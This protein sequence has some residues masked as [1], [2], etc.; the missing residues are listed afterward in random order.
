MIFIN[1][2]GETLY[3]VLSASVIA[4]LIGIPL[5]VI[6]VVFDKGGLIPRPKLQG[7]LGTFVNLV[8]SVPFL[9][10]IMLAMPITR[11]ITGTTLGS[12]AMIIPL[13]IT[14]APYI[15][16][17]VES[18]IREVDPGVIEAAKS[19]G[20]SNWQIIWK[21]ILPEA[22]PSLLVGA[23][24]AVTTLLGYS[25]M[26]A[27]VGAGGLGAY[28]INYGY[29]RGDSVMLWINTILLVVIFQI[30]Q[31]VFL[32]LAKVVDKRTR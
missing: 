2:I 12:T 6:L 31:E 26:A 11:M 29:Y 5:G 22:K 18:S 9:I 23:G 10:L 14:A 3:M 27:I 15:A 32:K 4:Y 7:I 17:V 1:G 13:I 8:R 20:A 30:M 28:A 25:A 21:V 16:R 19:M 24:L